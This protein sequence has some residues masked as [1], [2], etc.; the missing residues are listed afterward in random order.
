M[1][2]NRRR[3]TG[4]EAISEPEEDTGDVCDDDYPAYICR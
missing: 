3:R 1:R 4:F 2:L